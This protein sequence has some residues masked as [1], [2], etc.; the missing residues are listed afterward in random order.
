MTALLASV[1]SVAESRLALA[2]G[3]D[4][5]D[6]KDPDR[7]ALA[8]LP[9][10]V[11][12]DVVAD[13]A[14]QR[15]VSA[16]AGDL[17]MDARAVTNAVT[18]IAGQ[19]VDFV[20]IGFYPDGDPLACIAALQSVAGR[21]TRLVAVLFADRQPDFDLIVAL[22]D[23]GF[24][25]CML[26]TA[27]KGHG[28]L[29]Q[30]QSLDRLAA[31]VARVRAHGLVSGLAGALRQ[32]DLPPL[33]ALRPDYL[34]FRGALTAGTR[35]DALSPSAMAALRQAIP[36]DAGHWSSANSATATAGAQQDAA[37]RTVSGA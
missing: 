13:I 19:G 12:A 1:R 34:G 33:L 14:G 16:T 26:D 24:I 28:G 4:I 35:G 10:S 7:G 27:G 23:A 18:G 32:D 36:Q 6:L 15:P 17:P 20:K 2:G 22:A 30:H 11:I 21:G 3:A 31:F 29:L 25:G 9:H 8:A 37:S 5:I